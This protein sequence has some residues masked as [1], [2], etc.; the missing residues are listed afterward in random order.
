M[1][2][3]VEHLI[4]S[5]ENGKLTRRGLIS[6][7]SALVMASSVTAETQPS[8]IPVRALDHV[9]LLVSDIDR[10][11][12]FYQRLFDMP[13]M[14]RLGPTVNLSAGSSCLGLQPSD[15]QGARIGHYC[16]G[17]R[18]LDYQ[19]T[20]TKL[21]DEG[22]RGTLVDQEVPLLFFTDPDGILVQ[23][24][25]EGYCRNLGGRSR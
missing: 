10:S 1:S 2:T 5:Y 9:T 20:L 22:I 23:L 11:V 24:Q 6:S 4:S 3:T 17:V 13:I 18:G 12:K 14:S 15:D 19:Q 25:E 16:L 7:L 8:Q 21:A